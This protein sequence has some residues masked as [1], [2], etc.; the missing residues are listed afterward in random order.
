M[1]QEIS[2]MECDLYVAF[3]GMTV[4][5]EESQHV[6]CSKAD[7]FTPSWRDGIHGLT[8]YTTVAYPDTDRKNKRPGLNPN[9]EAAAVHTYTH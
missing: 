6:C 5:V 1:M 7:I 3:H 8:S 9:H 2:K 4:F